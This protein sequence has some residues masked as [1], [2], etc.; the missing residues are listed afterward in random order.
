MTCKTQKKKAPF[1]NTEATGQTKEEIQGLLYS[2]LIFL[3]GFY[4]EKHPSW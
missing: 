3:I 4:R 2:K 1:I